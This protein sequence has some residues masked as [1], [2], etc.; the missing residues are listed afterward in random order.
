MERRGGHTQGFNPG[1]GLHRRGG[2]LLPS[3]LRCAH[4]ACWPSQRGL[5]GCIR[6]AH[7]QRRRRR[8]QIRILRRD[9]T[10]RQK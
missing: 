4:E 8:R 9:N 7:R 2:G 10:G 3:G 5:V 6:T 1:Q